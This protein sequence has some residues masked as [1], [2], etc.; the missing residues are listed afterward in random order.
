[1]TG[2]GTSHTFK[3]FAKYLCELLPLADPNY[4]GPT[5]PL[6]ENV[7]KNPDSLLP[8][9]SVAPSLK[10]AYRADDPYPC[11]KMDS[12]EALCSALIFRDITFRCKVVNKDGH[13]SFQNLDDQEVLMMANPD[14]SDS[15]F[16]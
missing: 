7:T 12:T 1:M 16:D 8:Q 2:T 4:C 3:H 5:T 14:K 6:M 10:A 13:V 15:Y 9:Q 11:D